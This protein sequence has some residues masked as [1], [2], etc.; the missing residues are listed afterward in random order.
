MVRIHPERRL[1]L[2]VSTNGVN[3]TL[4]AARI[5]GRIVPELFRINT[6][7][8]AIDRCAS[9]N[10]RALEGRYST[11][12]RAYEL[13]MRE[14]D[15]FVLKA[16]EARKGVCDSVPFATAT[17]VPSRDHILILK[18]LHTRLPRFIQLLSPESGRFRYLW[19]GESVFPRV[20][21]HAAIR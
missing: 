8:V 5:F 4:V 21:N 6:P 7:P 11:Q 13:T 20:P 15:T 1:A 9:D 2:I 14:E 17:L 18:A 19:D 12:R 10:L 16:Y 3:P